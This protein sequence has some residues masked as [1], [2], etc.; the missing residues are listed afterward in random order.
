MSI[1]R[2]YAPCAA[3]RSYGPYATGWRLGAGRVP[4]A[5]VLAWLTVPRAGRVGYDG[6]FCMAMAA[7]RH[8]LLA[9]AAPFCWRL[10]TPL[11]V[12]VLPLSPLG[13]FKVVSTASDALNIVLVYLLLRRCGRSTAAALLGVAFFA[14]AFWTLRWSFSFPA[15]IDTPTMVFVLAATWSMASERYPL[16]A[17]ILTV[18]VAQ[19][20]SLLALVPMVAVRYWMHTADDPRRRTVFVDIVGAAPLSAFLAVRLLV[21]PAVTVANR[22]PVLPSDSRSIA[23]RLL[24]AAHLPLTVVSGLGLLGPLPRG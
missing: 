12:R 11:L 17:A 20:E 3:E 18:G 1:V 22:W 19:K 14:G 8:G 9:R 5:L 6:R 24:V 10:L 23:A 2:R 7:G 4:G 16:A 15:Y 21:H 13:G